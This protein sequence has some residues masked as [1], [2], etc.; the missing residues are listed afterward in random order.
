MVALTR[1]VRTPEKWAVCLFCTGALCRSLA[2]VLLCFRRAVPSRVDISAASIGALGL[3][4]L[5][6]G[7]VTMFRR[8]W[9]TDK[10][11]S[12]PRACLDIHANYGEKKKRGGFPF[13]FF[14]AGVTHRDCTMVPQRNCAGP[15][16]IVPHLL[17][18]A[19]N[20]SCTI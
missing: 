1:Q 10:N 3:R 8:D 16:I 6:L 14:Y 18:F 4:E 7:S 19:E 15:C 5:F 20:Y 17:V 9:D 2:I 11:R 13:S 12:L